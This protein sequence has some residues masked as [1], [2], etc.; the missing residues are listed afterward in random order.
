MLQL[1]C[2]YASITISI[3]PIIQISEAK[4]PMIYVQILGLYNQVERS[5]RA[6]VM[7]DN[8]LNCILV[9]SQGT[10][11]VHMNKHT[12][13]IHHSK[14]A[15]A[16]QVF[17]INSPQMGGKKQQLTPRIFPQRQQEEPQQKIQRKECGAVS[18]ESSSLTLA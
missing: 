14:K 16:S 8:Q 1:V 15:P 12:S 6:S 13:L 9:L 5:N 10:S 17:S 7:L 18:A 3:Y 11:K 2:N 4:L